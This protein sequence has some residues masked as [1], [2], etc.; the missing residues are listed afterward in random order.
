M[1]IAIQ[2]DGAST[3]AVRDMAA[4]LSAVGL[5]GELQVGCDG[6]EKWS[7]Q[8]PKMTS[9]QWARVAARLIKFQGAPIADALETLRAV[10]S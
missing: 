10:T 7:G 1:R 9:A 8:T 4:A 6:P 3:E 2:F 5:R